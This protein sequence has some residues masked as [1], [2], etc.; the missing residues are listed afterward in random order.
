M[1]CPD[2]QIATSELAGASKEFLQ[3]GVLMLNAHSPMGCCPGLGL[4]ECGSG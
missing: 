3:V 4:V 1:N 2:I